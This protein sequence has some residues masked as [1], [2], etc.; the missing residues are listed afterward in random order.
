MG[1]SRLGENKTWLVCKVAE[2]SQL[3]YAQRIITID[4]F[5][6]CCL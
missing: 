5:R 6:K 3:T 1:W 2:E 4:G